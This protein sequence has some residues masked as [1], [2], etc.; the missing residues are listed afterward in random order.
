MLIAR[1]DERNPKAIP[2]TR[3][4]SH[5]IQRRA[6]SISSASVLT[7]LPVAAPYSSLIIGQKT[8]GVK[9]QITRNETTGSNNQTR[10]RNGVFH[11]LMNAPTIP[12][13]IT[14]LKGWKKSPGFN[15]NRG[16]YGRRLNEAGGFAL[17]APATMR[18][19][20]NLPPKP[21]PQP[22]T[23]NQRNA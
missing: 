21:I 14:R 19:S 15:G 13:T 2:T 7:I 20:N 18:R 6:R 10:Y 23:E 3:H 16:P 1:M 5:M 8:V 9:A 11:P 22:I 4:Q 12:N 17:H